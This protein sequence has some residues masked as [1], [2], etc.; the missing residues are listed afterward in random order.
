MRNNNFNNYNNRE[1]YSK[2]FIRKNDKVR[3]VAVIGMPDDRL[4]EIATAVIEVKDG[5]TLTEDEINE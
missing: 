5:F 2:T 1:F 3:D 4:G